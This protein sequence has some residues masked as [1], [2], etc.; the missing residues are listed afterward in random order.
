MGPFRFLTRTTPAADRPTPAVAERAESWMPLELRVVYQS[1]VAPR[2]ALP[3]TSAVEHA[4]PAPERIRL[5]RWA[6]A[7]V[8]EH[9]KAFT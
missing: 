1:A 5:G 7:E 6:H 2:A 4:E 9:P 3:A 8:V